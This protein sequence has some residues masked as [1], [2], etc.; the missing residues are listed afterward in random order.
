MCVGGVMAVVDVFILQILWPSL[1]FKYSRDTNSIPQHCASI[2]VL[3]SLCFFFFFHTRVPLQY[4]TVLGVQ[5]GAGRE[6][7]VFVHRCLPF[8]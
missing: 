4:Q 7:T 1:S 8:V 6:D 5:T 3:P 2:S